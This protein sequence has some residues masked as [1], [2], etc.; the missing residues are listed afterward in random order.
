MNYLS[1]LE[2]KIFA[3]LFQI[4][5]IILLFL[6]LF[7]LN[8][9]VVIILMIASLLILFQII[10][11]FINYY[12]T[13]KRS[14]KIISLVDHLTEKYYI[15]ELL[16][17]PK[18]IENIAYYYALKL[19]CKAM[20]DRMGK[21]EE[22]KLE[23]QEYIERFVHEIK[24]PIAALSLA[25]EEQ[26][27]LVLKNEVDKINHYI[28]Q[29]LFFARSDTTEK[30][31]FIKKIELSDLIHQIIL[32]EKYYLRQ[33]HIELDIHDLEIIYSDEKWLTFVLSEVIENSIKYLE[34]E[35]KKIEIFCEKQKNCVI[36]IIEDNGSGIKESDLRRVFEKGFTGSDRTKAKS[37][38]IGLYLAKKICNNLG[39]GFEIAS[40]YQQGTIVKII[41]PVDIKNQ[42]KK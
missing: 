10:Y 37:T 34:K 38:G 28:E 6:F 24:T 25:L 19:A 31:Y 13:K 35:Q 17:K 12:F 23:Y 36:L 2:N 41:F 20:N 18:N 30:D 5:T 42:I 3:I 39:L 7:F 21:I 11:H 40:C 29:I 26:K 32:K 14:Q 22:E 27:E 33:K 8:I 16:P 9:N 1:Y 4:F 15:S